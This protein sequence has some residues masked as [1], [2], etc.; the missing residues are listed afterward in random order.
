MAPLDAL[1]RPQTVLLLGA[2]SAIGQ[3]IAGRLVAGG[4]DTLIL[5]G[6]DPDRG[7]APDLAAKVERLQFD[8]TETSEHGRFF[9]EVFER[10]QPVDLTIIAFGVLEDQARAE[11]DPALAVRMGMVNY[12]GSSSALL[13]ATRRHRRQGSGVVIL[14]SSV[15]GLSPR[16]SNFIYGSSK[17]GLDFLAR[18]LRATLAGTGVRLLIVRPG[19]V[20]TPMTA[21]LPPG[22]WAVG[23]DQVAEAVV[24]ALAGNA[25]EV[26]VP[27]ALSAVMRALRLLP[28]GLVDRLE[29]AR[30]SAQG[31]PR[32]HQ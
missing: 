12:V 20:R 30:R 27:S 25:D 15:A 24:S 8:A 1:G 7:P 11:A 3:A 18:G 19:F 13:H 14:L 22:P 2:R 23:P 4:A 26:W 31:N 6:R 32:H 16:R 28:R 21:G 10:H 29:A 5:A 9:D 17:A